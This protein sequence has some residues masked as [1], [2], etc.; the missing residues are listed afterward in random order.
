MTVTEIEK[1]IGNTPI[2]RL[3]DSNIWVK[4][5]SFNPA[6]SIKDR[7][8]LY[9]IKGAIEKGLLKSGGTII[10]PTS[11]NTGIGIAY[12]AQKLGYKSI[13][14]MPE[15]V[16]KERIELIKSYGGEVELSPSEDGNK[17]KTWQRYNYWTV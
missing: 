15:G 6:G 2:E 14:V 13:I 7:A 5:E 11:G 4:L 16:T 10:E 3:G 17:V 12:I 8:A 9:M 1:L